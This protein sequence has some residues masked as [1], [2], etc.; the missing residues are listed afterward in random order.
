MQV[1]VTEMDSSRFDRSGFIPPHKRQ[2][3]FEAITTHRLPDPHPVIERQPLF[4]PLNLMLKTFKRL[5]DAWR[6]AG[7]A[8]IA[9]N[10]AFNLIH[11]ENFE[12][13]GIAIARL[14]RVFRLT[15]IEIDR[16]AVVLEQVD[17]RHAVEHGKSQGG[18]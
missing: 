16:L 15:A 10:P 4:G 8:H 18:S 9:L 11:R 3:V 2:T 13:V 17:G 1:S 12:T 14:K 6:T 7:T 5:I